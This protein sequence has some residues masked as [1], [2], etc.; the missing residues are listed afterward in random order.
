M[1]THTA[2]HKMFTEYEHLHGNLNYSVYAAI[3]L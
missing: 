2:V 3:F 1:S